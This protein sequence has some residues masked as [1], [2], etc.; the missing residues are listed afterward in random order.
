MRVLFYPQLLTLLFPI[1]FA[2]FARQNWK[3]RWAFVLVGFG[4]AW[5][6]GFLSLLMVALMEPLYRK[7]GIGIGSPP[8]WSLP[9]GFWVS[10]AISYVLNFVGVFFALRALLPKFRAPA[11]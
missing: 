2:V 5:G 8:V 1:L 10:L 11:P 6:I 7:M 9:I 3:S 4:A